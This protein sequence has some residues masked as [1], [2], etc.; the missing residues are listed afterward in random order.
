MMLEARQI[1]KRIVQLLE[2]IYAEVHALRNELA[3]LREHA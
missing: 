1:A 2:G 3:K